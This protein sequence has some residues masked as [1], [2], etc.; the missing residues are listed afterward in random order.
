MV[1]ALDSLFGWQLSRRELSLLARLGS[2]S[3]S[4]SLWPGFVEWHAG[5]RADGM[6]LMLSP[7]ADSWPDLCLG[8]LIL[9]EGEKS[10]SSREAM[11]ADSG[12]KSVIIRH[13]RK[14]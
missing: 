1:Q 14:K 10:V 2:G 8:L 3:A 9:S 11:R 6:D 13:G 4:R 5:E 12:N 7:L